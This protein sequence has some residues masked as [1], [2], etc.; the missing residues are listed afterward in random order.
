M[1]DDGVPRG[2]AKPSSVPERSRKDY[3][4][5]PDDVATEGAGSVRSAVPTE[6]FVVADDSVT[7]VGE[8]FPDKVQRGSQLFVSSMYANGSPG[9]RDNGSQ[10]S[11]LPEGLSDS[12]FV[13]PVS[14]SATSFG[15]LVSSLGFDVSEF[16]RL[17][18]VSDA[19]SRFSP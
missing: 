13:D 8:S 2:S 3:R 19:K 16:E 9:S 5:L 1:D 4:V 11:E 18:V 14:S 15:L 12:A 17:S 6:G 7:I 10:Y